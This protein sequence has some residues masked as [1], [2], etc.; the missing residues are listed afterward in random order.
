MGRRLAQNVPAAGEDAEELVVEVV[1]VGEDDDGG[2]LHGE[3][4][5]DGPGIEG[6]GEALP[7]ALGVPHDADAS[8]AGLATRLATRLVAP[9]A[10]LS[11]CR[12]GA[13]QLGRAQRLGDGDPHGVELVVAG[14][15]LGQRPAAVVLEDDEV[16]EEG[17][18]P[19]RVADALQHH[20]KL[21]HEGTGQLLPA[22]GAPRLEP[23]HPSG[24]RADAGLGPVGDHQQLVHGEQRRRLGL[25]GLELLP[26]RLDR[27]VLVGGVLELDHAQG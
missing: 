18:E 4:A 11:D 26:G 24:E 17:E 27:G 10:F 25:V 14:D 8:V 9:A 19:R 23:F 5:G 13:L 20:L 3:V 21:G 1:A 15:L 2:V 12:L 6:H 22:D 7:R 16:A